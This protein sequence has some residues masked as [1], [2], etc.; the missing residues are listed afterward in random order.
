MPFTLSKMT[1]QVGT[2]TETDDT[3]TEVPAAWSGA[4][5]SVFEPV[6]TE[7]PVLPCEAV[8]PV[9]APVG[10]VADAELEEVIVPVLSVAATGPLSR[11]SENQP[12]PMMSPTITPAMKMP[13][14]RAPLPCLESF[15][16]LFIEEFDG[17]FF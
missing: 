2:E 9:V 12:Q 13:A 5:A 11:P 14:V 15:L 10:C 4:I 17:V 6:E 3:V 8:L 7:A 1:T 16:L